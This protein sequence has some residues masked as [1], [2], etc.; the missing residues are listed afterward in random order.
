MGSIF[1][2]VLIAAVVAVVVTVGFRAYDKKQA[3]KALG[4]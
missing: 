3:Q 1:K 4:K 2:I